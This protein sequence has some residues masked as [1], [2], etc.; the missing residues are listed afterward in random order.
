VRQY[1]REFLQHLIDE[2][3]IIIGPL[4]KDKTEER[5]FWARMADAVRCA[6]TNEFREFLKSVGFG[7]KTVEKLLPFKNNFR[8]QFNKKPHSSTSEEMRE[9]NARLIK[10][11]LSNL[12]EL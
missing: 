2:E 1:K 12:P 10:L 6:S 5:N 8:E 7:P 11:K 3:R 4:L 9:F